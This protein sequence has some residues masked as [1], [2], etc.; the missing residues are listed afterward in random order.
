MIKYRDFIRD[1]SQL[2]PLD[3]AV[4]RMNLFIAGE[5]VK[6]LSV[7]SLVDGPGGNVP[8]SGGL[9]GVRLWYQQG[10]AL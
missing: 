4:E 6:V 2:E 9:V 7:E 1:Y 10:I 5:G 3:G 8:S